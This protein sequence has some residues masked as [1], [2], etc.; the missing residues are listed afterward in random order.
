MSEAVPAKTLKPQ[1][2]NIR[3]NSCIYINT[4]ENYRSS[5]MASVLSLEVAF[6][7]LERASNVCFKCT[8]NLCILA[9]VCTT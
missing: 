9:I 8:Y 3:F 4:G 5:Q 1:V 2:V 6:A 7:I